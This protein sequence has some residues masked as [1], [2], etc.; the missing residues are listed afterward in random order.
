MKKDLFANMTDEFYE[1]YSGKMLLLDVA[2]GDIVFS[3]ESFDEIENFIDQNPLKNLL[4]AQGP[5]KFGI[6]LTLNQIEDTG[7][8]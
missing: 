3:S 5:L 2:T 4:L 8:A 7:I 6:T 1:K